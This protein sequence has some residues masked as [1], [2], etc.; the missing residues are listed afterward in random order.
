MIPSMPLLSQTPP[1]FGPALLNDLANL[2][3]IS[4]PLVENFLYEQTA[5]MLMADPGV[6]KS[7]L[8][9]QLALSLANGEPLFG[10]LP[11]P[12]RQPVYYLQLEGSYYKAI[13]RLRLMQQHLPI[14]TGL[15]EGLCWDRLDLLNVLNATHVTSLVERIASWGT[16][17]V[18]IFDPIYR[19][20][21]GGLSK[22]E[23][24]SQFC[25]VSD[26]LMQQFHCANLLVHHT[27]RSQFLDGK[28]LQEDDP[29]Y[30]SQWLKAHVDVS[31][32]VTPLTAERNRVVLECKKNRDLDVLPRIVL[33]FD[34][35]TYTCLMNPEESQAS[36]MS[37]LILFLTELKK[38]GQKQTD[39][40]HIEGCINVSLAHLKR[41][42]KIHPIPD[43]VNFVKISGSTTKWVLKE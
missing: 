4:H 2:D 20:V 8:A 24:A 19:S 16:P 29:F 35:H 14:V 1:K 41:L 34:P 25:A 28:K 21:M 39:V 23:V 22:D 36:A 42:M 9:M 38:S 13:Q 30:G 6:G 17:A 32:L 7:V 31:Y 26:R 18:I 3:L 37:K 12:K 40:Y 10:V 43:M 5:T 11:V 27:H 15:N 33:D